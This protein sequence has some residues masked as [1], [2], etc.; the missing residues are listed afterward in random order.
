MVKCIVLVVK[1]VHVLLP[2]YYSYAVDVINMQ[3]QII[4]LNS[5]MQRDKLI[6]R[7]PLEHICLETDSPALGLEQHVSFR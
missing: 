7:I 5:T 2:L 4:C 1:E 6:Q 3:L